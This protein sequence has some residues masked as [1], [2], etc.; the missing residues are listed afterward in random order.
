MDRNTFNELLKEAKLSK[1]EFASIF[2]IAPTTV[3]GW[4]SNR[5]SIPYWVESWLKNYIALQECRELLENC[6]RESGFY[7]EPLSDITEKTT[8]EE[9]VEMENKRKIERLE[10]EIEEIKQVLKLN[11]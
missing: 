4:G 11:H 1:K 2:E 9:I 3:N 6:E 5:N 10:R 7:D 8:N